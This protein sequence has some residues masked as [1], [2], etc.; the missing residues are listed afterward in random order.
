MAIFNGR[1][2]NLVW[3]EGLNPNRNWINF[4]IFLPRK[5]VIFYPGSIWPEY[6][7]AHDRILA[8]SGSVWAWFGFL[9]FVVIWN[10]RKLVRFSIFALHVRFPEAPL[11][12]SLFPRKYLLFNICCWFWFPRLIVRALFVLGY[13]SRA[14]LIWLKVPPPSIRGGTRVLLVLL[15]SCSVADGFRAQP[16]LLC[17]A[18]TRQKKSSLTVVPNFSL[19]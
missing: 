10:I 9:R 7:V 18:L 15:L 8:K 4:T 12:R 17:E 14:E 11:S 5:Q 19:A 6:K 13:C 1:V 2:E 16:S 3:W